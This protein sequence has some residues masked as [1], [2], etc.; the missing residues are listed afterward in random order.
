MKYK[1]NYR[2]QTYLHLDHAGHDIKK[3]HIKV[4]IESNYLNKMDRIKRS[5]IVYNL[6]DNELKNYIHS[7]QLDII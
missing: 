4:S 6:I 7:I 5:K 3:F 2:R 1:N